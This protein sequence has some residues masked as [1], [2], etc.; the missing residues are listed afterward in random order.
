MTMEVENLAE[1]HVPQ[2]E[3]PELPP[4]TAI[5]VLRDR[6]SGVLVWIPCDVL[7]NSPEGAVVEIKTQGPNYEVLESTIRVFRIPG[8]PW[9][10]ERVREAAVSFGIRTG[11]A[12]TD[13]FVAFAR[14]LGVLPEKP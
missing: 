11:C 10:V 4:Y 5:A 13:D 1:V 14:I 8:E 7:R 12:A 3:L 2:P 9:T 6:R